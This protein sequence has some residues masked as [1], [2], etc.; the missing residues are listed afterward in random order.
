LKFAG[1]GTAPSLSL[2]PHT[3][4]AFF[5]MRQVVSQIGTGQGKPL[6]VSS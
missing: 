4:I 5:G 6:I 1:C 3:K 2:H